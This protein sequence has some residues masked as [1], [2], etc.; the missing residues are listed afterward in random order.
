MGK[1][2]F[3]GETLNRREETAFFL[4]KG[5]IIAF[6]VMLQNLII[7]GLNIV[8]SVMIGGLGEMPLAA[9][10][11]ANQVYLIYSEIC[12]GM[13]SGAGVFVAQFWGIKDIKT[14]RK[15]LG[16]DYVVGFFSAF[17][18]IA[19]IHFTAPHIIWLFTK[20]PEVIA[21]GTEY[22]QI[23][24]WS[25]IFSGFSFCIGFNCRALEKLAVPTTISA[26][27]V[28]INTFLNWVLIYGHFGVPALGV[29]GAAIATLVARVCEF[30]A[31][32]VYLYVVKSHPLKASPKELFSFDR[33]MVKDVFKM[34]LPVSVTE[35]GW[36][37]SM[38]LMY[39]AYGKISYEALAVVQVAEVVT[40]FFQCVYFG[41]GNAA[42]II[43]GG[44][45]G[46]AERARALYFAKMSMHITWIL[47]IILTILLLSARYKIA[48]FYNFSPE[49]N[50]LLIA[51][52]TVWAFTMTPKMVVYVLICGVLR[53]GGDTVFAMAVDF[54][55]NAGE[56]VL[57]FTA[58]LVLGLDLPRTVIFVFSAEVVKAII[59]YFRLYS[60][61]WMNTITVKN[62]D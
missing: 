7:V 13:F 54:A 27:A 22:L 44:C 6:P 5:I 57:A 41:L 55:G 39:V 10:G 1:H 60:N 37:I 34:A 47:N 53:A 21:L 36:A 52:L 46:R 2:D 51:S 14:I 45:L 33:N 16:I 43:I 18:M 30:T 49:T 56:V 29:K 32:L 31:L 3:E 24:K 62:Y 20:E 26:V 48:E 58:V 8:D 59:C 17:A 35:V 9:V 11:S 15:V 4:K 19:V 23:V 28:G 50:E 38:S 61:K 12:F 25:Y 42:S 40:C